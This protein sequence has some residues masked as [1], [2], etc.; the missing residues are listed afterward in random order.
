ML[1]VLIFAAVNLSAAKM[2]MLTANGDDGSVALAVEAL[3][4]DVLIRGHLARTTYELTYRND[5]DRDVDGQFK[6]PLPPDAEVS[7]LG[8]YFNGRLR[9]AVAV[10]RV[11]A[12][13]A[14]ERTIQRRV[15]PALAEWSASTRAFSFRVYPIPAKGTKVVH[16]AYDQELTSAPYVLDLRYGT[17]L[18]SVDLRIDSD[19][20]VESDGLRLRQWGDIWTLQER[21][22]ALDGVVRAT[23]REREPALMAWSAEDKNWYYSAAAQIRS[24]VAPAAAAAQV[25]L[26]YDVSSSAVQRDE[27]KLRAFLSAFLAKQRNGVRVNVVP[28]H[29]TADAAVQ[30]DAAGLES[31]LASLPLAGATNLVAMLERAAAVNDGSRV[32]IVTDGMNTLGNAA[33]VDAALAKL[34]QRVTVVSA[35]ESTDDRVLGNLATK[36]GGWQIDLTRAG[37]EQAAETAMRVATLTAIRTGNPAV[38]DVLPAVVSVTGELW[39]TISA[40]SAVRHYSLPLIFENTRQD[41]TIR[42][43]TTEAERDMV[44]RAWARARLRELL[45]RSAPQSAVI[46][47]GRR[48]RQLTPQTSLIVLD[49]WRDYEMH[50]FPLPEDLREERERDREAEHQEARARAHQHRTQQQTW[51]ASTRGA[52]WF[53]RGLITADDSPLPGATVRMLIPGKADTLT[54][55]DANGRFWITAPRAPASFT[56]RAELQGLNTETREYPQG[57]PKGA[58]VEIDMRVSAVTE[59]ITVTAEAPLLDVSETAVAASVSLVRPSPGAL[60][61]ALLGQLAGGEAVTEEDVD[62]A[63]IEERVARIRAVVEKLRTMRSLDERFRYYVAARSVVGGEKLFQA[64][65]ALAMFAEAPE[66]AVRALTDLAEAYPD[67]APTLR[68][69][70]R[71]LDG[72]GRG[73]LARLMFERALELAPDETQTRRELQLL[74]TKERERRDPRV[75]ANSELQ[76]EVMWDSNYTDVDLHVLEPGGEE[77]SFQNMKSKRGGMLHEDIT[78][79]F[80]PETYTIP[81]MDRGEYEIVLDYF[82]DDETQVGANTLVH[83]IVYVR[84]ERRDLFIPLVKQE[85]RV[86]VAKVGR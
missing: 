74:E 52:A 4:V 61:D 42:E 51:L 68:L 83:V 5:L 82:S 65:S 47:H 84:G 85:E 25:L 14:Y 57:A 10:E 45:D 54:V 78:G 22:I 79:G 60:A 49:T 64:E 37:P 30:T 7:E 9:R 21:R 19:V 3:K 67:D 18:A 13:R 24:H 69:L 71:V 77:V 62:D 76:V 38:R 44:R 50:G 40:R 56:L 29:V 63:S 58:L 53:I 28:F 86:V 32:V 70:G 16:I 39:T 11:A 20:P 66:L 59:T 46:E 33:R 80:G 36:N 26:L 15:D 41:I 55:T 48:F 43:V 81:A 31:T 34:Q 17:T 6:F 1:L 8:L 12:R 27:T 75:F 23:R 35:S 73:D 2:P 72:W